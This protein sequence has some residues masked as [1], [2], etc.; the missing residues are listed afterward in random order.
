MPKS[1]FFSIFSKSFTKSMK[2]DNVLISSSL[3]LITRYDKYSSVHIWA[4]KMCQTG[5]CF[6]GVICF[7]GILYFYLFSGLKIQ[8]K[9]MCRILGSGAENVQN[10][11]QKIGCWHLNPVCRHTAFF[12]SNVILWYIMTSDVRN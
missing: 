9:W 11:A 5:L 1:A 7:F 6:G 8:L 3:P 2:N 12:S 4:R 10:Y